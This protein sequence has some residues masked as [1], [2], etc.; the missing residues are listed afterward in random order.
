M[1]IHAFLAKQFL[2]E[3][4]DENQIELI[5]ESASL[6]R[7]KKAE[8]LFS[9]GQ[10][11]TA[12]FIVIS[13]S[14]KLYKLSAEGSEQILHIQKAG[15]LV[16]EAIIFDFEVYPAFC[17]ALEDTDLIRFSKSEFL[18]LLK[19]FPEITFKIMSAYSRRLRQLITKIEEL[20]LHDVK[21]RLASYLMKNMRVENNSN[22]VP[23]KVTKKD[24][25]SILGTIPETL[26]RTLGYFKKEKIIVEDKN[27]IFIQ[28]L[29]KLKLIS[30]QS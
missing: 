1:D 30:K 7:I 9:E 15:D 21:S 26:S 3:S 6:K 24:L 16:A 17:E 20:S 18:K 22:F 23:I 25:A 4:L 28:N 5:E 2:F 29:N 19:H 13:G 10:M 14:V 11:A 12:F 8:L 27:G